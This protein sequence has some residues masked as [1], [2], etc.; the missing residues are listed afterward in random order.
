MEVINRFSSPYSYHLHFSGVLHI[1]VDKKHPDGNVYVK[2]PSVLVSSL[3]VAALHGRYFAG[4]MVTA[5]Y[6]PA[7]SYHEM[8][9]EAQRASNLLQP[10]GQ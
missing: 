5:N 10:R 6:L 2:C 9:P 8:F 3:C 7:T 4:K 1:Y